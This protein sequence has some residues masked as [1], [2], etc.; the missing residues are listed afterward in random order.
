MVRKLQGLLW[1]IGMVSGMAASAAA[2]E[3]PSPGS[4]VLREGD[5]PVETLRERPKP[6]TTVKEWVAQIEAAT[7]QVTGVKLERSETG[8][9]IVLET[10]EG[11]PL[12][13]D[14]TKFRAEGNR[15]IAEIPNA[16]LALPEGQAFSAENP[17]ADIASVQVAQQDVNTIRVSV[18]GTS[19][20]PTT[21]VTLKTGGLAYSLNPAADEPDEEIV[22]T[23]EG[24]RGYRVPNAS[25]GTG[26]DT[27]ILETPFSVQ[28]VPQEVIRDQQVIRL[29]DALTNVSGVISAGTNGGRESSFSIRG[30]GNQFAGSVPTLRDGY[31]LYGNFQGISEVGILDRVEVLKGPASLLYGEIEPGGVINL[32]SKRP[33][34]Q[35]FYETELQ[36]GSRELV[37]PRFDITGPLNT[38]GSL[39]YRLNALYQH[40]RSFRNFETD[41]N[42]F[43]VA[44]TL[45]WKVGDRTDLTISLDYLDE[46][47]PADFGITR[48]GDGVAPV[49]R[50]FITNNPDD[51]IATNYFST[52]YSFEHRF[53][54]NWKI[55]NG[56]RYINYNYDFNVVALP[57]IVLDAD[58]TRFWATQE[59]QD[60]SYSLTTS[61]VGKFATGSV[62]HTLS[63]GIDLNRS[64][65][66]IFTLFGD[67]APLNIFNPDYNL[68]PKPS[69]SELPLF[70]DTRTNSNRLGL[71][72]QDQIYLLDNLILVAGLRYDTITQKTSN[73]ETAFTEGGKSEQTDDALTPRLGLLYRPIPQLALFASYSQSFRPSTALTFS[74]T[75]LRPEKGQGFEVGVKTE[76]FNQKL[77][78][79]LTYFDIT[80]KNVAVADP[81][82]PLFSIATGEQKSRGVELDIAG[83][84]SPGWK[85]IGSYA[86][87]DAKV[88]NDTDDTIVGNRLFGI[89]RNKASLWTTYEIQQGSLKGLGFGLGFE[90]ASN[91][92]GD[93]ANSFR[94]GDYLIGNA[95]IF[96]RRDNYRFAI[97]VRNLANAN[98]IRAL[99]GNEGGLEP[100]EPLTVVGSF[101]IQF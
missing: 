36:V 27:P 93:L 56:F 39:L 91:R 53:S 81:N 80:K 38:D 15:L 83:E 35:P 24:Q 98:Y 29:E 50:S 63:A 47:K 16:V 44:P 79:T 4:P 40:E 57:F 94:V 100:G 60:R 22:V 82:N 54:D 59:G 74:G 86:Y 88:S 41:I 46:K 68:F 26:T 37:R 6:A 45:R 34:A 11:K 75:P 30:F 48:F 64:E 8:L 28:V 66:R 21:E 9:D 85:I 65:S 101:S 70:G 14:A 62:K 17:T 7:V 71:Y 90:Y 77:L 12:Q 61:V 72:L 5:S 95:A 23:G 67:P 84:L 92:F 42:R 25:V 58:I 33:L 19:A 13:V 20:P 2:Q 52:G 43:A 3:L 69:R 1:V 10:A 96:Y 97:N 55:R 87:I 78:A 99:T 76:L 51:S 32:V 31:R 49:S 73:V 18:A 89:P